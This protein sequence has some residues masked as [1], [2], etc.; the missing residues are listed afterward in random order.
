MSFIDLSVG[1]GEVITNYTIPPKLL[2]QYVDTK[3]K[4]PQ[5]PLGNS[6]SNVTH[7]I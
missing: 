6:G 3:L 7:A 2:L 1:I 5:R 4:P